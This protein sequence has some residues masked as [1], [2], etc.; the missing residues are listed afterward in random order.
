MP[1]VKSIADSA[2]LMGAHQNVRP[3]HPHILQEPAVETAETEAHDE[4]C[5]LIDSHHNGMFVDGRRKNSVAVSKR[6]LPGSV[7]PLEAKR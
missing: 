7:I 5:R 4:Q 1:H 3:D 6:R 2:V